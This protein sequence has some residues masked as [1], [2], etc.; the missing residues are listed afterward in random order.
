MLC[1][2]WLNL[3]GTAPAVSAGR[4]RCDSEGALSI[5]GPGAG[6]L[7]REQDDARAVWQ[8]G[9][10]EGC[11]SLHHHQKSSQVAADGGCYGAVEMQPRK[12][13]AS[14]GRC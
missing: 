6:S 8:A 1:S 14:L 9:A 7:L 10:S 11:I 13:K 12:E 3:L 4:P 5:S 2:P